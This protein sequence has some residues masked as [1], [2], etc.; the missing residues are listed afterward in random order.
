MRCVEIN[1]FDEAKERVKKGIF[2]IYKKKENFD[3]NVKEKN[4]R[5]FLGDQFSI[6]TRIRV[7]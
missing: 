3:K 5:F 4:S 1:A 6:S 7:R 2:F